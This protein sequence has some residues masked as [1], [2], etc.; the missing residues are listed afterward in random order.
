[1][2]YSA[3]PSSTNTPLLNLKIIAPGVSLTIYVGPTGSDANTGLSSTAP[4]FSLKQAWTIAQNYNITGNGQLYITFAGGTYAYSD[5]QIPDNLYHP[6]G[7]NIIIQGDPAAVKQRY[8][9]RVRNYSWDIS[10]ISYHG[11]T[12]T[13]N[14][15]NCVETVMGQPAHG[16]VAADTNMWVA[17]SNPCLSSAG[18]PDLTYYDN[19]TGVWFKGL[20][21][22]STRSALYGDMFFNNGFSYENANGIYGL[23]QIADATT[24]ATDLR[25]IFKN[26]N[27]DPRVPA[28]SP[29]TKGA[30]SNGIGNTIPWH[31]IADNYPENQYSK[32]NGY[33][34]G[35]LS[36]PNYPTKTAGDAEIT[37]QPHLVTSY[38]V[39]IQRSST[40]T[41]PLFT[42]AGGTIKAIR[43]FMLVP[44]DFAVPNAN[45]NKTK[46]LNALYPSEEFSPQVSAGYWGT[47]LLRTENAT[48]GIRHLGVYHAEYG[49]SAINSKIT[50]YMESSVETAYIASSTHGVGAYVTYARLGNPDNTPVLNAVNVRYGIHSHA[51]TVQ[52]GYESDRQ[53][54]TSRTYA[55][56]QGC[57]IQAARQAIVATDNSAVTVR[58]AVINSA[59]AL[60]RFQFVLRVP[61][62]AGA[63]A[64]SGNTYSF[65]Y[66]P[67]W[68]GT[69]STTNSNQAFQN[70]YTAAA[71]FMRTGAA[72]GFTLGY[73]TNIAGAGTIP[74]VSGQYNFGIHSGGASNLVPAYYQTLSV[75]GYRVG[76]IN[77]LSFSL[78]DDFNSIS[79]AT[80]Y[81]LEFIAFSDNET[82]TAGGKC[83]IG[84]NSFRS[85]AAGGQ[86]ITMTASSVATTTG[87]PYPISAYR[88]Y[89]WHSG[90]DDADTSVGVYSGSTLKV[91]KNLLFTAADNRAVY[92]SD[93]SKL[94]SAPS[95]N[96]SRNAGADWESE[97]VGGLLINGAG[98]HAVLIRNGSY[99]GLGSVYAKCFKSYLSDTAATKTTQVV[100][101][102]EANSVAEFPVLPIGTDNYY[103]SVVGVFS[104]FGAAPWGSMQGAL[105]AV[106][107]YVPSNGSAADE[108]FGVVFRASKT[109][110]IFIEPNT[111]A[112]VSAFDGGSG[113]SD[114]L[115]GINF[116]VV[117]N[118]SRMGQFPKG[119]PNSNSIATTQF[120]HM[121]SNGGT[122]TVKIMSRSGGFKYN[123]PTTSQYYRWWTPTGTQPTVG[124]GRTAGIWSTT[125]EAVRKN[126]FAIITP[127]TYTS[128]T[129]TQLPSTVC[130]AIFGS[131]VLGVTY[132]T[133]STNF[134]SGGGTG[135]AMQWQTTTAGVVSGALNHTTN[136]MFYTKT[137][138]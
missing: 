20:D 134:A 1:M 6:Q 109:S 135:S 68:G 26:T 90:T 93:G 127:F 131:L 21:A 97:E 136:S 129:T 114:S 73:I 87:L 107:Y 2:A 17:I 62:F 81:T 71:V 102:A 55:T 104:P 95:Q 96:F 89:R 77:G 31:G 69:E 14:L 27:I 56:E 111:V 60:P 48:V 70:G 130:P 113:E 19:V 128:R 40:S 49:I 58:S 11:H 121:N 23:A 122:P 75:Y 9:Y 125:G 61:V 30:V 24:S 46:A 42:V 74:Y 63:S 133:S 15:T 36:P 100:V 91:R 22:R 64:S 37:N 52:I 41:K 108:I 53:S 57:F 4:V 118:S 105:G 137:N 32:P 47:A 78:Q 8:L 116:Y 123:L 86:T 51:S 10:R 72:T 54:P 124:G 88:S 18:S 13:V 94:L 83:E 5:A 12:G 99:A 45:A 120:S 50:T 39:V 34:G 80:G 76:D 119:P 65:M 33:Y 132:N 3:L 106:G 67:S 138:F 115:S 92:V 38:P 103:E 43:N 59:R 117:E 25:L 79:S 98:N 85:T 35:Y 7:G 112:V 44:N 66:P 110:S 29:Y 16:Y 101:A 84:K 82:T 126:G 28:F